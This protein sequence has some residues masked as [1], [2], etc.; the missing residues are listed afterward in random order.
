LQGYELGSRGVGSC[1]IIARGKLRAVKKTL[2][3]IWRDS[4]TVINPLP[5]YG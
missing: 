4:Q 5:E 3:V 2:C 1:R